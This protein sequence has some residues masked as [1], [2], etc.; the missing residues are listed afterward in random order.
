MSLKFV[1]LD[2]PFGAEGP[3]I[4]LAAIGE[5]EFAEIKQAVMRH[6]LVLFRRQ[7]LSDEDLAILTERFGPAEVPANH[8]ALSPVTPHVVYISNMKDESG[9]PIGGGASE[10][11]NWHADQSFRKNPAT[12]S[13]L[14]AVVVPPERGHT[15][16]C[17]T[18]LGYEAL[19]DTL[20][21]WVGEHR[22][23]YL[24]GK[25]HQIDK[26]EVSH[27]LVLAMPDGSGNRLY[28]SSSTRGIEGMADDE[29]KARLEEILEHQLRPEHI[30]EHDWR[31]G[32]LMIY[33]NGQT[34]H[35]RDS[36]DGLRLMK[37][38]RA[39]VSAEDFPVPN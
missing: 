11:M 18:R 12:L 20:K 32:D 3:N 33:D 5:G 23:T 22:G 27:P 10:E 34:L 30:Y 19:P 29:S 17:S 35:R 7:S 6:A 16:W 38:T 25:N 28:V 15:Y 2:A 21:G 13:L 39:F 31:V 4:D 14:Y 1:P 37:G 26:V 8:R 24:P 9:R 36:F